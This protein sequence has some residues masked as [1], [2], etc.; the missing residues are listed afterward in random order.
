IRTV[1]R[2]YR[3]RIALADALLGSPK[4]LILD[5]PTSGLDPLQRMQVR[6]ILR[7]ERHGRTV[8]LSTHILSEAEAACDR[9]II[10]R[11]GRIVPEAEI[12]ALRAGGT[13]RV[14]V[15]REDLA[16]AGAI[17]RTVAGVAEIRE[18]GTSGRPGSP[19]R[20]EGRA[21]PE[22]TANLEAIPADRNADLREAVFRAFAERPIPLLELRRTER[23]LEEIFGILTL[24]LSETDGVERDR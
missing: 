19:A 21:G 18:A 16:A 7:E 6:Q 1:S 4:V 22:K 9:I 3:Q 8:L 15:K 20:P 14:T 11:R 5:E 13:V 23:S 2:G 17:L 24:Q 10:I 12:E